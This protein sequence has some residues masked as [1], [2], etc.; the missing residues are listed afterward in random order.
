M[1]D[2]RR[3]MAV[4]A[5]GL[6][7]AACTAA[8]TPTPRPDCPA[9]APAAGETDAILAEAGRA[10]VVTNKG[11][12]GIALQPAGAPIATANF[13]ALARCGF[14]DGL[15][16]H[17]VVP[18]FVAQAGDPR[19][20][21]N[22]GDFDGLGTGG[23]GYRFEVEFPPEDTPYRRYDV[24]MANAI[25]F[26]ASGE[27]EGPTDS[28]GSQFFVMLDDVPSLPPYYSLLGRVESGQEVV[29]GIGQVPT[30]RTDLP[31]DPVIIETIRIEPA[32]PAED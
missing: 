21:Q 10:L 29:D 24:A 22:R 7:L 31:L 9:R 28:N 16:F 19:T 1:M 18:G 23:P 5:V 3:W 14:Y 13:V 2:L 27:I 12:F 26:D 25:Q 4:P 32:A 30:S 15:S 17:R 8:A 20:K 6:L 11:E